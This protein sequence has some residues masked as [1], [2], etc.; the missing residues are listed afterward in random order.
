M[1]GRMPSRS[2]WRTIMAARDKSRPPI[3]PGEIVREDVL[4]GLCMSVT[5]A[6]DEMH[7]TRQALHRVLA[8]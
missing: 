3:H 6:A 1:K 7:V 8:G 5:A 4:P 2:T